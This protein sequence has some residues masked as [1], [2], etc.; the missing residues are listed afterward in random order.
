MPDYCFASVVVWAR[1]LSHL[2]SLR[3]YDPSY[4][5]DSMLFL[6]PYLAARR[7]VMQHGS[8]IKR[9]RKCGQDVWLFRWSER[10]SVG[11]R[12]YRKRVIGS[13][14]EYADVD[15]ARAVVRGL[16]VELNAPP[17]LIGTDPMTISQLCKHFE[18]R[19]LAANNTWR[20]Y[21]MKKS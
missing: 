15:A 10:D 9:T 21:S 20:S 18:L 13:L 8:L 6:A 12:V 5:F 16:V 2:R 14:E 11:K 17:Q 19:E 3:K 7:S 1:S 4:Q